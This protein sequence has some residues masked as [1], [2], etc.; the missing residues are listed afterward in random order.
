MFLAFFHRG[1]IGFPTKT[2]TQQGNKIE[3]EGE[4]KKEKKKKEEPR[5]LLWL[6]E[7]FL[8]SGPQSTSP[9]SSHNCSS[10]ENTIGLRSHTTV[11][12]E[13]ASFFIRASSEDRVLSPQCTLPNWALG[14]LRCVV[15]IS[16]KRSQTRRRVGFEPESSAQGQHAFG[17]NP[18]RRS[19]SISLA[20][21]RI[22]TFPTFGN[23]RP[24]ASFSDLAYWAL[25]DRYPWQMAL[26]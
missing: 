10:C 3:R 7:D 18:T 17:S 15:A 24:G 21:S 25:P 23:G 20:L 4:E 16:F 8:L 14:V 13:A 19:L 11:L 12:C 22:R 1:S 9:Y 5:L 26:G 6:L 2:E